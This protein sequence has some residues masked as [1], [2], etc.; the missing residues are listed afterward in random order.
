MPDDEVHHERDGLDV[1][2]NVFKS[3]LEGFSKSYGVK[4]RINQEVHR[5]LPS[6]SPPSRG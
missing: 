3:E 4:G 5:R 2:L 6:S 1:D